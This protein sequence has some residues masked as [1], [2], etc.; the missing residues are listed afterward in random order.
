M[1]CGLSG[2]EKQ[3]SQAPAGQEETDKVTT[4]IILK[5]QDGVET[6]IG[7]LTFDGSA[8]AKLSTEGSGPDAKALRQAWQEIAQRDELP[9]ATTSIE[10]VDGKKITEFGEQLVSKTDPLYPKAVWSYLESRYPYIVDREH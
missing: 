6:Q 8:E 1:A 3:T 9:M 4:L 5:R 10:E 2:C 7:K